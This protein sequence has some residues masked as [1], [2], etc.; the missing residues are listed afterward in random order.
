MV[1]SALLARLVLEPLLEG[2]SPLLLFMVAVV[3]A[4][5][6]GGLGPGL[7]ATTLSGLAAAFFFFSPTMDLAVKETTGLVQLAL[8][9]ALGVTFSLLSQRLQTARTR[10]LSRLEALEESEERFRL[11]TETLEQRVAQRTAELE[12]ANEALEAFGYSVSHDLRAPLRAMEGF[13]QALVEDY[14]DRLDDTGRGYVRRVAAAAR[15]M[16]SLIHDLLSYSRLHR[17]D[18]ELSAVSLSAVVER[19]CE[20]LAADLQARGGAIRVEGPLPAVRAHPLMLGQV[21]G[22]LFANAVTFVAPGV[23]PCVRVWA[24]SRGERV[25]LWIEDNGIGIAP[26]H[27]ERIFQ[28]FERL[29]GTES[30]PGTGIGLAIVRRGVERMGGAAGIESIPGDG[31]RFWI[32]L[33]AASEP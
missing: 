18:A 24:E 21:L 22:N 12:D 5:L 20:P 23:P 13:A 4:A 28:V 15:S 14:G 10:A 25:R 29:H 31:T 19:A 11:L 30:Y 7:A 26:E 1:V 6:Y 33:P 27:H 16:D 8:F 32:E 9:G 17:V 2:Q 3:L